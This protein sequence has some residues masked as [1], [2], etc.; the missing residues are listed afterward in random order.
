MALAETANRET[1]AEGTTYSYGPNAD[2]PS[3]SPTGP[4]GLPPGLLQNSELS[5]ASVDTTRWGF[6]NRILLLQ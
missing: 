2:K 6:S 1:A 5:A 3:G 4:V